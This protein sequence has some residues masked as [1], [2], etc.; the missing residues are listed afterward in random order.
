M[1][2]FNR[3][4]RN[5]PAEISEELINQTLDEDQWFQL[6][7]TITNYDARV[8]FPRIVGAL[9]YEI[10]VNVAVT[11]QVKITAVHVSVY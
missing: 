11:R 4:R 8:E 1:K 5:F 3:N 10:I 9:R 6:S 2:L 7:V